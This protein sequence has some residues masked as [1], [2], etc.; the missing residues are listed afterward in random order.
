MDSLTG[1][2]GSKRENA[3]KSRFKDSRGSGSNVRFSVLH[4]S[5]FLGFS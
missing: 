2:W 5:G 3:S 4:S 1:F